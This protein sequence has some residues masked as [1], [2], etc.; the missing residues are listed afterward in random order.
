MNASFL[1][2][3]NLTVFGL[4]SN[5]VGVR[6]GIKNFQ[7]L[8]LPRSYFILFSKNVLNIFIRYSNHGI[9]F[10]EIFL[11]QDIV[12]HSCFQIIHR[13]VYN[14]FYIEKVFKALFQLGFTCCP[15][16]LDSKGKGRLFPKKNQFALGAGDSSID[17][18]ALQHAVAAGRNR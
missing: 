14:F 15:S 18:I 16:I 1:S 7:V 12:F 5:S 6:L 13:S 8:V 4:V 3:T 10:Q 9:D 2:F 17:K 11:S